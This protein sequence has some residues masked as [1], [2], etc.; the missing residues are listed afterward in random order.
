VN[1]LILNPDNS[2]AG[3]MRGILNNAKSLFEVFQMWHKKLFSV[4]L[5]GKNDI[6]FLGTHLAFFLIYPLSKNHKKLFK[7]KYTDERRRKKYGYGITRYK[8]LCIQ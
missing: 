3:M 1:G 4:N 7:M 5:S 6:C 8:I 2:S